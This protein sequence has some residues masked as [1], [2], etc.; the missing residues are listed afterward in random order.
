MG[1][2]DLRIELD[3][4][5]V[6]ISEVVKEINAARD[7]A[8]MAIGHPNRPDNSDLRIHLDI[9]ERR[10]GQVLEALA[11]AKDEIVAGPQYEGGAHL[12]KKK[13]RPRRLRDV[14]SDKTNV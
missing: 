3:R 12:E 4:A 9:A 13:P 10:A 14:K 11:A 8:R 1:E 6:R 2:K 7:L 5:D